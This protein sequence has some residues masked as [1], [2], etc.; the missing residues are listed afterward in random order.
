VRLAHLCANHTDLLY[1]LLIRAL[2]GP[3]NSNKLWSAEGISVDLHYV[4]RL[5]LVD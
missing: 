3:I 2:L 4:L 5:A 1:V